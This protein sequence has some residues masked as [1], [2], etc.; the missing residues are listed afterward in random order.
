MNIDLE[1]K[2]HILYEFYAGPPNREN[3]LRESRGVVSGLH[4]VIKRICEPMYD[5]VRRTVVSGEEEQQTYEGKVSQFGL[6][7]FFED[8][9]ITLSTD[10]SPKL[11]YKGGIQPNLTYKDSPN[12]VVCTPN[13]VY[14][15]SATNP[16]EMMNQV[17]AG[18]GHEMIHAYNMYQYARKNNLMASGIS[19][20]VEKNQKYYQITATKNLGYSNNERAVGDILYKLNRMERNAYIGELEE[21]LFAKAEE[22]KDSK[23][24]WKAVTETESYEKFKALEENIDIINSPLPVDVQES[25]VK[26]T[27]KAVDTGFTNFEQLRKYY[28]SRWEVWKKKYLVT[29]S[30]IVHDIFSKNNK[31][32]DGDMSS[33]ITIKP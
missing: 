5:Q 25:L 17:L 26:Y 18:I 30:K 32:L 23:S 19:D 31:M 33:N 6:K 7:T 28:T 4:D 13:I 27:N 12:G 10:T 3:I 1:L 14:S 29:A 16:S 8:Y 9:S 2:N 15:V 11:R 21:E 20:N 24:A 22:I